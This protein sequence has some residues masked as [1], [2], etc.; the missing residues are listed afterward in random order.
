MLRY[1]S[2]LAI[3]VL[4]DPTRPAEPAAPLRRCRELA[5]GNSDP[6][7]GMEKIRRFGNGEVFHMKSRP[8]TMYSCLLLLSW[9]QTYECSLCGP[10][11]GAIC[12]IWSTLLSRRSKCDS[13]PLAGISRGFPPRFRGTTDYPPKGEAQGS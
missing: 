1:G 13:L 3:Q 9:I 4:T 2:T 5:P 8:T 10:G 7:T 6:E 12:G 11:T